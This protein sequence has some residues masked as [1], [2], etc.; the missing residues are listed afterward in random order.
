MEI[1]EFGSF[2]NLYCCR[3]SKDTINIAF[4]WSDGWGLHLYLFPWLK[5]TR[6]EGCWRLVLSTNFGWLLSFICCL[7]HS[8]ISSFKT[9]GSG[10]VLD[11]LRKLLPAICIKV[12]DASSLVN[13]LRFERKTL[14]HT[15]ISSTNSISRHVFLIQNREEAP[16]SS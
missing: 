7:L 12:Y 16:P 1:W 3:L 4:A 11:F 14:Q 13:P 9:S 15:S 6:G 5:T 2:N 8:Q 10:R